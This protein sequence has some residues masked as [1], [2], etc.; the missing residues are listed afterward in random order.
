MLELI[1]KYIDYVKSA[2]IIRFI[3]LIAALAV[4]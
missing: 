4:F 2:Y 1:S 3:V